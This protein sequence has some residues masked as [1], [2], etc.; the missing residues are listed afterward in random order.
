MSVIRQSRAATQRRTPSWIPQVS[1][2]SRLVGDSRCSPVLHAWR[3][4]LVCSSRASVANSPESLRTLAVEA[5]QPLPPR[6]KRTHSDLRARRP[7]APAPRAWGPLKWSAS[8]PSHGQAYTHSRASIAAIAYF[9]EAARESLRD[10][11]SAVIAAGGG[12]S[13]GL[14]DDSPHAPDRPEVIVVRHDL[15]AFP[16]SSRGDP[17]VVRR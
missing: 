12:G 10:T 9:A 17:D 16:R 14:E 3:S 15:G 2:A 7:R 8:R 4:P 5:H 11:A 1:D 6:A 13:S